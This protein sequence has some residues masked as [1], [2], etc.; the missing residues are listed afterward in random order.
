MSKRVLVLGATGMLGKPATRQLRQ[1][2][3]QVRLLA[4][5]V[6]KARGLFYESFEIVQGDPA[7]ANR[8]LGAPQ[9]TLDAWIEGK[10]Q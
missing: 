7:E 10:K 9:I 8:T 1:D 5:D 4:R 2:D 6:E 3:F